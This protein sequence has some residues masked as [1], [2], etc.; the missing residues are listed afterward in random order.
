MSVILPFLLGFFILGFL[1]FIHEAGHF[2]TARAFGVRVLEFGL[3]FPFLGRIVKFKRK[4]TVYSIN[5]LFFGGFVQL[6]GEDAGSSKDP[7]SFASKNVWVRFLIAAAGIIVNIVFAIILFTIL[8]ATSG[9]KVD[10]QSP[11][12]NKFPFGTTTNSILVLDVS[13]NSPAAL[14]GLKFGDK[15]LSVNGQNVAEIKTVQDFIKNHSGEPVTLIVRSNNVANSRQVIVIPRVNPPEGEGALGV[16][17]DTVQTLSYDSPLEKT[18]VGFL[19]SANMVE[20]QIV[21]IKTFIS[22]SVEEKSIEPLAAQASGPVRVVAVLGL[23]VKNS[24]SELVRVIATFT[25]LISLMLGIGNLLPIP[26][27]DGGR[28]FFFLIEGVTGKKVKP[29]VE[30]LIHGIGFV[31][32]LFLLVLITANDLFRVFTGHIFG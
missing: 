20:F 22:K 16:G 6:H 25:A 27:L 24:G 14:A 2:L 26:A 3:G 17:L 9:F 10:F 12:P 8:M 21:G 7:D 13:K 30:N 5:W 4:G 19:H 28:L 32:L 15:I 31:V 18:F 11:I 23:L 1:V 29:R